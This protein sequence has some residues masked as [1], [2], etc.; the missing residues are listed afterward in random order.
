MLT[1]FFFIAN[2]FTL[3]V[4]DWHIKGSYFKFSLC[5]YHCLSIFELSEL[6][7]FSNRNVTLALPDIFVRVRCYDTTKDT[8]ATFYQIVAGNHYNVLVVATGV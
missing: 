4:M 5:V 8:T 7:C 6:H 2:S 3:Y 1:Y